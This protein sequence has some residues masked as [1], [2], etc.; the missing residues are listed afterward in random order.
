[1][2]SIYL[3]CGLLLWLFCDEFLMMNKTNADANSRHLFCYISIMTT[4]GYVIYRMLKYS[5]PGTFV[6]WTVRSLEL[7]FRGP[8]VPWTIR[9][10]DRILRGKFIP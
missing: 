4:E 9:S 6:P 1:M 5:F 2:T 8:F 10:G 7:S 3:S